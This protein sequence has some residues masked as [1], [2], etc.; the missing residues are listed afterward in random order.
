MVGIVGRP[1]VLSPLKLTVVAVTL[2]LIAI[3]VGVTSEVLEGNGKGQFPEPVG[4]QRSFAQH[5]NPGREQS[6]S[7]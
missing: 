5:L 4:L 7:E 1:N 6:D 2:I 3:V